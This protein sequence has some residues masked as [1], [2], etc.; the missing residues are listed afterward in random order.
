MADLAFD[1]EYDGPALAAHEMDV[2]DL[3]PALISTADLFQEANRV[4]YPLQPNLAV[5]VRATAEGSFLVQLKLIYD[6]AVDSL[7]NEPASATA[8]LIEIVVFVGGAI[9][10]IRR[11][12]RSK[13][14][15]EAEAEAPG[16]IRVTFEDGSTL[17]I[18]RESLALARNLTVQRS[19][20]EVVAPVSREGV[21]VVRIRRENIVVAEVSKAD[22]PAFAPPSTDPHREVL[23][24]VQK[25]LLLTI[26]TAGFQTN[27]WRF[28]D[29]ASLMW[30]AI[31]DETF[32][33]A[34]DSGSLRVGKLDVLRCTVRED[35]WRDPAG[36]HREIDV[37]RVLDVIP[38]DPPS[39][40]SMEFPA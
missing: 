16:L 18:P 35:V 10:L 30:A 4:L 24:S 29:G 37:V 21:E 39:Q 7:G 34:M 27:R 12:F 2:R 40:P 23:S 15:E 5:N 31:R 19:L 1:L 22:A 6:S 25:E 3:A 17:E 38:Y 11:R 33:N 8:N 28:Y 36:F 9:T 13:V 26:H 32:I 14:V 20:A